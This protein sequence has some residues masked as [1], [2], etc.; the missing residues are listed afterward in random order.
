ML[1]QP[2]PGLFFVINDTATGSVSFMDVGRV[3]LGLLDVGMFYFVT[4]MNFFSFCFRFPHR[5]F[6]CVRFRGVIGVCA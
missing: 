2:S 6:L 5:L 4:V 1:F 3:I